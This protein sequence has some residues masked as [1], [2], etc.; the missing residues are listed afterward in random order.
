MEF[1]KRIA[2]GAIIGVASFAATDAFF[3]CTF[4]WEVSWIKR[5]DSLTL[6]APEET[7]TGKELQQ[8]LAGFESDNSGAYGLTCTIHERSG[9]IRIDEE[10]YPAELI[11]DK[12]RGD[13]LVVHG[14]WKNVEVAQ[15]RY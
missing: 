10:T 2:I 9:Q 4:P 7:L 1:W 6:A 5:A 15:R 8:F 12:W 13:V 3:V 11:F 14:R